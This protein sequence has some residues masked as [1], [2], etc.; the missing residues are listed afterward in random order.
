MV[1]EFIAGAVLLAFGI[2]AIYFSIEQGIKDKQL[3][4]MMLLGILSIF[5]G[6][7]IF[8]SQITLGF[9]IK[10]IV[11]I[12]LTAVGVFLV[13]GFPD[14]TDYQPK[15]MGKA[16]IFLGIV[17]GLLGLWALLT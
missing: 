13:M 3:A 10:K 6:G 1:L 15:G 7:W 8:L 14:V 9:I 12:L 4:G 2:L 16:G 5:I 11:G 17:L